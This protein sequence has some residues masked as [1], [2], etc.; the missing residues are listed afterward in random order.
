MQENN[1]CKQLIQ[2]EKSIF[3]TLQKAKNGTAA[4]A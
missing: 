1:K 2:K 3:L 4:T